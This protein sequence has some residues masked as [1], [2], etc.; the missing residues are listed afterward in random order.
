MESESVLDTYFETSWDPGFEA[1]RWIV[2][3]RVGPM[4]W[5][6]QRPDLFK[7]RFYQTMHHIP[8][9]DWD[10]KWDFQLLNGLCVGSVNLDIRI[11][12]T[13]E[14]ARQHLQALP[15]LSVHVQSSME[16]LLKESVQAELENI[17]KGRW[18]NK[19][20][21]SIEVEIVDL[22]NELLVI[23]EVQCR[24]RCQIQ[25]NFKQLSSEQLQELSGHFQRHAVY[26]DLLKVN[27]QLQ[28]HHADQQYQLEQLNHQQKLQHKQ[29]EIEQLKAAEE[30]RLQHDRD[31]TKALIAELAEEERRHTI[32]RKSHGRQR[33]DDV[34]HEMTLK[35]METDALQRDQELRLKAAKQKELLLQR[36]VELLK[37]EEQK[38]K[39]Q[40][41]LDAYDALD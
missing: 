29:G 11:Q 34:K 15:D 30:L 14:Y 24:S 37:L 5:V 27:N 38:R 19:G 18:L 9:T 13:V 21:E 25:A 26:L 17:E 36:E 20:L 6:Y 7:K 8:V 28:A 10:L 23:H 3:S 32:K 12:P 16:K 1:N 35:E 40:E 22:V 31:L 41:A 39:L 4:L 33:E 2:V